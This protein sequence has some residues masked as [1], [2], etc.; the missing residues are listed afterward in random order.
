[1][2]C[3]VCNSED[4][5]KVKGIKG[6]KELSIKEDHG[7][8]AELFGFNKKRAKTWDEYYGEC[9]YGEIGNFE[10]NPLLTNAGGAYLDC[11]YDGIEEHKKTIVVI[12]AN[13]GIVYRPKDI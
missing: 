7:F 13:C 11:E 2:G 5:V 6:P 10:L 9:I 3:P 12:C 8:L 4:I 1:M